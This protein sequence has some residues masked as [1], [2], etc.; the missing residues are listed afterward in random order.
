MSQ[1]ASNSPRGPLVLLSFLFFAV[2]AIS[3]ADARVIESYGKVPLH[4]EANQGQTQKDVQFV[5]RGADYS[6][7]LTA[8]EAVLVLPMVN[9]DAKRERR[10]QARPDTSS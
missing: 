1:H 10:S 2:P 7:F 5:S 6:L 3:L 4:F 8:N 9:P